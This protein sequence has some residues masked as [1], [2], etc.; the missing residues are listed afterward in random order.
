[1]SLSSYKNTYS[2]GKHKRQNKT[3]AAGKCLI[4]NLPINSIKTYCCFYRI[5][6]E[7]NYFVAD[8]AGSLFCTWNNITFSNAVVDGFEIMLHVRKLKSKK[9]QKCQLKILHYLLGYFYLPKGLIV[10]YDI[11]SLVKYS[12][13]LMNK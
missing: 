2:L 10:I 7:T 3:R 9:Y 11:A 1:M 5:Q 13:L 12:T 8:H 4:S 6:A